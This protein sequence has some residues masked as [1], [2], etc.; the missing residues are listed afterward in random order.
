MRSSIDQALGTDDT[1]SVVLQASRGLTQIIN[2]YL[3][4]SQQALINSIDYNSMISGVLGRSNDTFT[5]VIMR[6]APYAPQYIISM[7]WL[8]VDYISCIVLLA[9]SVVAV[10]LRQRTLAPD[11]LGYVSSLTRDNP[12]IQ[13]PDGGSILPGLERARKLKHVRVQ[14][15]DTR[16]EGGVGRV[17]LT[18]VSREGVGRL[19]KGTEYLW[20]CHCYCE[21]LPSQKLL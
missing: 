6:G 15:A 8:I 7:P 18:T 1:A 13:L 11:I 21:A 4:A 3:S 19:K 20:S 17:G 2:S 9:C 14:F 5:P 10:V 16:Q 12:N